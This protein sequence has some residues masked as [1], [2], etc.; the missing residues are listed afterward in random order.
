MKS[1]SKR[2]KNFIRMMMQ[3]DCYRSVHYYADKLKVSDKTL[4]DDLKMIRQVLE[5]EKIQV[6]GRTGRGILLDMENRDRIK[7]TDILGAYGP[8]DSSGS[9][10]WRRGIILKNLLIHSG[11][12]TSLQKLSEEYYVGKASIVNDLKLIEKWL[13]NF[14][15]KLVRNVEGTRIEGEEINIREA[16]ASLINGEGTA[17]G[18]N[19]DIQPDGICRL[20]MPTLR[21]LLE[22]FSLEEIIFVESLLVSLEEEEG[23]DINDIYYVNILTHILICIKRVRDGNKMDSLNDDLSETD[24]NRVYQKADQ[25]ARSIWEKYKINI[26]EEEITYI[27][28]Y[29]SSLSTIEGVKKEIKQKRS[30]G[31]KVAMALTDYMSGVM[32]V[33]FFKEKTLLEGLMLHIRPM[34]NR[35]EYNIQITNPL[36]EEMQQWYPQMLG[37]CKIACTVVGK[38]FHLKKIRFDEIANIATYYQTMIVK[39]SSRINVLVVCHSGFGTS[40]LL[41][42]K[43]KQEFPKIRVIDTISSRKL[44]ERELGDTDF[45]ISTVPVNPGNIPNLMISALL[46]KQDI[47]AIRN[48]I[49]DICKSQETN[50]AGVKLGEMI[51]ESPSDA[52]REMICKAELISGFY[53]NLWYQEKSEIYL[54]MDAETS[55]LTIDVCTSSEEE[56]QKILHELYCL[57]MDK[58]RTERLKSAKTREEALDVLMRGG[59]AEQ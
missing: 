57:S 17:G 15:L 31:E 23:I 1:L 4:K 16:I 13:A 5:E 40:L 20:N 51:R 6:I 10:E 22:V 38:R 39:L 26:G 47:K 8:E 50:S 29:L 46:T 42:E 18:L 3:E 45:I 32:G 55:A 14:D 59:R 24:R 12:S 19:D 25:I 53:V 58:R 9:V 36:L 7:M 56:Q 54:D 21:G 35:L 52:E 49:Y 11:K 34:L 41:S 48:Y 33:N 43:I 27:Y 2:Q 37:I 28:Q 44:K 30:I